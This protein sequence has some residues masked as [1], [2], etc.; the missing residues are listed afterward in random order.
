MI[1]ET[2]PRGLQKS[3]GP[4]RNLL[5]R[6]FRESS[7]FRL[8]L[9]PRIELTRPPTKEPNRTIAVAK[10]RRAVLDLIFPDRDVLFE[11]PRDLVDEGL[12]HAAR[13]VRTSDL[14]HRESEASVHPLTVDGCGGFE[15]ERLDDALETHDGEAKA[16]G[17]AF[18]GAL[19]HA[20]RRLHASVREHAQHGAID[21]GLGLRD[22]L[23]PVHIME[24]R[25]VDGVLGHLL[26][27]RADLPFS[28][29]KRR[30]LIALRLGDR[31]REFEFGRRTL[32]VM[33]DHNE[34]RELAHDLGLNR[35]LLGL[36][37]GIRYM[38]A[39]TLRVE[40]PRVKRAANRLA[41]DDAA[42]T[43]M[44]AE[45]RTE[46]VEDSDLS[47]LGAESHEVLAEI[48]ERH[49]RSGCELIAIGDLKPSVGDGR[50]E[51]AGHDLLKVECDPRSR[52]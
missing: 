46:G 42:M 27:A 3:R 21:R 18:D 5:P 32:S 4:Q 41:L 51:K 12:A 39:F 13:D 17:E 28:A 9:G 7:G 2:P 26:I 43:E 19:N 52:Q 40:S 49:D 25:G 45:M 16:V 50:C 8:A 6:A 33:P 47:A 38:D 29:L 30:P 34:P 48:A 24:M 11:L 1:S 36:D 15:N 14:L 44:R 31:F 22:V 10:K 35:G 23:R 20:A 37:F